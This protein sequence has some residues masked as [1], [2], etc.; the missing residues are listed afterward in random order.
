MLGSRKGLR[1]INKGVNDMRSGTRAI[2]MAGASPAKK[3]ALLTEERD[4]RLKEA[5]N[6]RSKAY[7]FGAKRFV[8]QAERAEHEAEKAQK[9]ID[10]I[11]TSNPDVQPE[12]SRGRWERISE[13]TDADVETKRLYKEGA[14]TKDQ[15]KEQLKQNKLD[16]KKKTVAVDAA[17][18]PVELASNDAG[19]RLQELKSLHEQGLVSDDEYEQKR[20]SIVEDL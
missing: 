17:P 3:V 9:Q 10:Q 18:T 11:M 19:A 7:G 20:A 1:D 4:A 13:W 8:E 16:S 2:K 12:R 15:M 5:R 6:A 14:I